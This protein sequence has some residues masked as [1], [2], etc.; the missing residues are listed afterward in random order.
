MIAKTIPYKKVNIRI[1][2]YVGGNKNRILT[3]EIRIIMEM[4]NLKLPAKMQVEMMQYKVMR[5]W[6]IG[7]NTGVS[8]L[9]LKKGILSKNIK[10]DI[11]YFQRLRNI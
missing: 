4:E 6:I 1:K 5:E 11:K 7:I 9:T 3:I 8:D 10:M 2:S